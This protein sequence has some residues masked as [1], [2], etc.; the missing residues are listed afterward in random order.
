MNITRRH[1]ALILSA[2]L[3]AGLLAGAAAAGNPHGT[4]PGQAKQTSAPSSGTTHSSK[5]HSSKAHS[6]I[7]NSSAG[8]KPS[9][10]TQHG[11]H[12]AAGSNQTKLYGN[13]KTA[14]G[15]AQQNGASS[16]T[17]LYGPG[18]SQPHKVAVCSK[19]GKTHYVDVHALKAHSS[20]NCS[21]GGTNAASHGKSGTSHGNSASHSNKSDTAVVSSSTQTVSKSTIELEIH[22][23]VLAAVKTL[24]AAT[25]TTRSGGVLSAQH[26]VSKRVAGQSKAAHAVVHNA[27]FT[28]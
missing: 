6:G 11:T 7:S 27:S 23:A 26:T 13:G 8:V 4:P 18:N 1:A 17:D 20:S 22:N 15:I 28:G 9:S 2:L 10:T 14:G 16:S 19:N 12:A 5:A 25:K 21:S 24:R 3:G